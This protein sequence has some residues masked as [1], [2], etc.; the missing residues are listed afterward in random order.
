MNIKILSAL[1]YDSLQKRNV[2]NN[3]IHVLN[4][5]RFKTTVRLFYFLFFLRSILRKTFK[6]YLK[7]F[8]D[9]FL[10][11]KRQLRKILLKNVLWI[12][13]QNT[14]QQ[15][16][17]YP[18]NQNDISEPFLKLCTVMLRF[19]MIALMISGIWI[20]NE[21]LLFWLLSRDY[22][23]LKT[24]SIVF[25]SNAMKVIKCFSLTTSTPHPTNTVLAFLMKH[26]HG[27]CNNIIMY[28]NINIL[29]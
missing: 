8:R 17:N 14:K 27:Y 22:R 16:S 3:K 20:P 15:H 25:L 2:T 21:F 5:L 10:K 9:F 1:N 12:L 28:L 4:L 24:H 18:E 6:N 13:P 19:I 7:I 11:K 26:F 29:K 23:T